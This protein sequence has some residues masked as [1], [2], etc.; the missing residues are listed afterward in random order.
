MAGLGPHSGLAPNNEIALTVS[1]IYIHGDAMGKSRQA[2]SLSAVLALLLAFAGFVAAPA[3]AARPPQPGVY[4]GTHDGTVVEFVLVK[5]HGVVK[6]H[7]L[8]RELS[9]SAPPSCQ[10]LGTGADFFF[11]NAGVFLFAVRKGRITDLHRPQRH[12]IYGFSGRLRGRSKASGKIA[13][14]SGGGVR[15]V[16]HWTAE[17]VSNPTFPKDG[18]WSGGGDGLGVTFKVSGGGRFAYDFEFKLVKPIGNCDGPFKL[19]GFPGG[20]RFIPPDG[21]S[22]SEAVD[23]G[24]PG[25]DLVAGFPSAASATGTFEGTGECHSAAMSWTAQPSG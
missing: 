4:Y 20:A 2:A 23:F 12:E 9:S 22:F 3:I 24:G 21:S 17:R 16:V 19:G 13:V 6:G 7:Y 18:T 25:V 15:C 10:G 14:P 11:G 8:A 5:S 1:T